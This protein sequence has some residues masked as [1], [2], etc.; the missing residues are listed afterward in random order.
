VRRNLIV[1]KGFME[2]EEGAV[3][4]PVLKNG[5]PEGFSVLKKGDDDQER[6]L[7]LLFQVG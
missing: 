3:G 4:V 7:Y 1:R 6:T 2:E 5:N